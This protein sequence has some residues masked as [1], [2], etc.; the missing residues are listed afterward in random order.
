M[1]QVFLKTDEDDK[2][3]KM[4]RM[5]IGSRE[6]NVKKPLFLSLKGTRYMG[7][8]GLISTIICYNKFV[9]WKNI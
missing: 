1:E 6:K 5:A 9:K 4:D 3:Q 2:K 8:N 7:K